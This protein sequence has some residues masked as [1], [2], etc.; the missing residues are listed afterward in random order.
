MSYA[1]SIRSKLESSGMTVRHGFFWNEN[2]DLS[3]A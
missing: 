2:G 1:S 3:G